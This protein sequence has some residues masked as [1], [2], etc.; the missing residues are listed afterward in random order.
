MYILWVALSLYGLHAEILPFLYPN[1][2]FLHK[3]LPTSQFSSRTNAKF[4]F[5][6]ALFAHGYVAVLQQKC[7]LLFLFLGGIVVKPKFKCLW[8]GS[9]KKNVSLQR[10]DKDWSYYLK[11][12][13]FRQIHFIEN[14]PSAK[15]A[16]QGVLRKNWEQGTASLTSLLLGAR[17]SKMSCKD[18][19]MW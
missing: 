9:I 15:A 12:V 5:F 14:L 2:V 7:F 16:Q 13:V 6:L 10:D 17:E 3:F 18:F 8:T 1:H 11:Q 19:V 4:W